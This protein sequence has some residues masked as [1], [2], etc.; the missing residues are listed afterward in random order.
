MD[1]HA[2]AADRLREVGQRYSAGRRELVDVLGASSGPLTIDAIRRERGLP[3]SSVYRNLA[4]WEDA[5]VVRRVPGHDDTA[6]YELA[7]E[8]AEHHHHLLCTSCG[9]V[10][11][12][13]MPPAVEKALHR[14]VAAA[15][16]DA[17]FDASGHSVELSGTCA[18][19]RGAAK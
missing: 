17:G 18:A 16:E 15:A 1:V 10:T 6:H 3:L 12:F 5:G 14:A 4:A 9:S 11:D 8:L 7:E 13:V 19:C 2:A